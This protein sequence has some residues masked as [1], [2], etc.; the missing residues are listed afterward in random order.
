[1]V[2]CRQC[3]ARVQQRWRVKIEAASTRARR[4]SVLTSGFMGSLKA[5]TTCSS[6]AMSSF[7]DKSSSASISPA[8]RALQR[9]HMNVLRLWSA[10][11]Q[12]PLAL[13]QHSMAEEVPYAERPTSIKKLR[14]CKGCRL[15]KNYEQFY[16]T[17][18]ENCP[19]LHP[20][21]DGEGFRDEYVSSHTTPDFEG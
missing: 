21:R 14:A 11:L 1:M 20:D 19:H 16:A 13:S 5:A 9:C 17:Y 6:S 7:F 10:R 15:I 12:Q 18:C 2:S 4:S 3:V 8:A